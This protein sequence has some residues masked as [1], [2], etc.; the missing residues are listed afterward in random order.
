M[1]LRP[2]SQQRSRHSNNPPCNRTL[3]HASASCTNSPIMHSFKRSSSKHL[4]VATL[5]DEATHDP[6]PSE[7]K[8]QSPVR[9]A[10]D[11]PKRFVPHAMEP[12]SITPSHQNT[13]LKRKDSG[14]VAVHSPAT[15]T[16]L[17]GTPENKR[18][19]DDWDRS[20]TPEDRERIKQNLVKGTS[21][22]TITESGFFSRCFHSVI[23]KGKAL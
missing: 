4:R 10:S 23:R 20:M 12:N 17:P 1:A 2:A 15:L 9:R 8:Q 22:Y 16:V 14:R 7:E 21:K 6:A 3:P 13:Q 19:I 18:I 5:V 11:V